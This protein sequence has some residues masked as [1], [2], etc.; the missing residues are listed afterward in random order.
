MRDSIQLCGLFTAS[1][2]I[3]DK[4]VLNDFNIEDE[5]GGAGR[6][7]IKVFNASVEDHSLKIQFYWAGRGT[8]GIP[9]RG[10]YG[11]L[12]SAISVDSSESYD[13]QLFGG[14][15]ELAVLQKSIDQSPLYYH[16]MM[17]FHLDFFILLQKYGECW[18]WR[19]FLFFSL[20]AFAPPHEKIAK[21]T[22]ARVLVGASVSLL[23]IVLVAVCWKKGCLGGKGAVDKGRAR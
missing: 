8:T 18:S 9:R 3:Q 21:N 7:A 20:S 1:I 15:A 17:P 14:A 11:P 6:A 4:M 22:L 10:T 2:W 16:K 19:E 5:G 13:W 12:I 23:F